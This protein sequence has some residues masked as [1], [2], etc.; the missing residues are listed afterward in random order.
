[1][2]IN[3]G[4]Y[5]EKWKNSKQTG[6]IGTVMYWETNHSGASIFE[7]IPDFVNAI[8]SK[9]QELI[10]SGAASAIKKIAQPA[11]QINVS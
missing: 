11:K 6:T 7:I 5:A 8:T 2:M 1:M 3:A 10:N 9:L 4:W